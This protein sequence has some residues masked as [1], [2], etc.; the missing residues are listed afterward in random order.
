M[1][2]EGP[3]TWSLRPLFGLLRV[4]PGMVVLR[5]DSI[6]GRALSLRTGTYLNLWFH[7]AARVSSE[8]FVAQGVFDNQKLRVTFRVVDLNPLLPLSPYPVPVILSAL[9]KT[10]DP[11]VI[12]DAAISL[13]LSAEVETN[14]GVLQPAVVRSAVVG[15]IP[16]S[17]AKIVVWVIVNALRRLR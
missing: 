10:S 14:P 12:K 17:P 13:G 11:L 16:Y 8:D 7:T 9:P 15:M 3:V 4:L 5:Q 6:R 1:T 2:W